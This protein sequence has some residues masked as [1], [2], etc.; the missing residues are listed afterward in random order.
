MLDADLA[1][2]YQVPTKRLNEQVRR[3]LRRF[4]QDFMFR[5]TREEAEALR[6]QDAALNAGRG[7][8]RKYLPYAFSE[9]GVAMLSSVLH[10]ERAIQMNIAVMRA[11][12]RLRGVLGTHRKLARKLS[13]IEEKVSIHDGALKAILGAI[14]QLMA[15]PS[16]PGSKRI[17]FRAGGG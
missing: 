8:H 15:A 16:D 9:Q 10:S 7:R 3:N 11:F 6:S 14:R 13:E 5:L 12:V 1:R 17:G 4:P 2:L